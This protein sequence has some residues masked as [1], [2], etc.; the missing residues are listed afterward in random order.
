MWI[1]ILCLVFINV[2][3]YFSSKR[4]SR[5]NEGRLFL[6][7]IPDWAYESV[8]IKEIEKQFKKEHLWVFIISF[9]TFIP[10]FIF[11]TKWLLLYFMIVIWFNV[12]VYYVPYRKARAKLLALKKLRN[13]PDE[14]IEKI[15]I[16]LSLS[17]YMEKHPFNLRRYF[18][19]LIID[20]SVLG[21]MIY[22]HAENAMY[23]YMVLQFMVLV[24]GIVFIKKLPNKTFC[25]NS[26]VNITLN[27]LRRDSFHHCFFFLIT[28]D[29]I[30]NLALQFFLL[31]KLPFVI[32][33]L[34]ALIMILCVIIIVI[35]AN[36]YREK[37]AKI[38]AHY[39]E[40]EYTISNDDC[41]KIG[42]F[43][44]TYYNKAD[45][46]TLIS[47]PNGTQMTFNTA[48][49]AYRIFIIGIW[50]F[51]IALLLWL[52]G[53]PYY[54]DLTNNLVNLSLTDQAVVVDSPF[55]DVSIDLQKVNKAELADDLG[56]G[57]RTNGTDTFVYGKGN[58]TFDRYGKC[59]VYM[60]SLHPCY[61]ILYTDDITYIVNDDDIQNTKLIY[62]EIQ[63][64]LSQ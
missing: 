42:W 61:I 11:S 3:M 48:K 13:W 63:E 38:L 28:G 47:A 5:Y 14:K 22:F 12:S 52:F 18:F 55:Y 30:F 51:V 21:N 9:I 37:K 17:A 62:Q 8:E 1:L 60:A 16:D 58:Y 41:W 10:L 50:T 59:K 46:R 43:G 31:E 36:H 20:L 35:K 56:K 23:L 44:P 29:S 2:V 27:L 33:L 25:K 7:T 6:V 53:Y 54:L 15:K 19:V 40:C 49:P 32:L 45:P 64:V 39:N 57:I 34:V 4:E 26:E 24:L